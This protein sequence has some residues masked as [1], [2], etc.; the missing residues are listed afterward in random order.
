LYLMK[1][2]K[3]SILFESVRNEI[4]GGKKMIEFL[5]TFSIILLAWLTSTIAVD[6]LVAWLRKR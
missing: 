2:M 6:L 5:G 3:S 4:T 1:S